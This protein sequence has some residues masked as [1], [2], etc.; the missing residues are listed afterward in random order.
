MRGANA[1][2][3]TPFHI[4]VTILPCVHYGRGFVSRGRSKGRPELVRR[5][6]IRRGLSIGT[7]LLASDAAS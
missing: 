6:A 5:C 4:S 7:F 2:L 1:M 3:G